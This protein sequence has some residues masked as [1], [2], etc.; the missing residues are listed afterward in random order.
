MSIV[1]TEQPRSVS[2]MFHTF[3]HAYKS[4]RLI[5]GV[6]KF[7]CSASSRRKVGLRARARARHREKAR[8]ENRDGEINRRRERDEL[9]TLCERQSERDRDR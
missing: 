4:C 7:V 8:R 5:F 9:L 6:V 3:A 2:I 1:T